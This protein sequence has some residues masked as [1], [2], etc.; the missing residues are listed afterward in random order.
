[1]SW[2]D[3][4]LVTAV[5]ALTAVGAQRKLTGLLVGAVSLVLFRVLLVVF[6]RSIFLGLL[7]ALGAGLLIGF[8]GRSLIQRKRGPLLPGGILGGVG[9]FALGVLLLFTV[10][11]SLPVERD[12]Q[13]RVVYPPPLLPF[14]MQNAV[15]RSALVDLGRDILLY[16]LLVAGDNIEPNGVLA[17]LHNFFVVDEPWERSF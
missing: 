15:A 1:M 16:P 13:N 4:F 9:G 17:G 11:T 12:V 10:V 5:A 3:L 6:D 14:G 2:F 8:A 7:F